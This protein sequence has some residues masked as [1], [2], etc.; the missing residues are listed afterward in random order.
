MARLDPHSCADDEQP[1]ARHLRLRLSVDFDARRIE[2]VSTLVFEG[3]A[4]GLLDLDSKEIEILGVSAGS[5]EAVPF[6]VG[7]DEPILGRRVRLTLPEGTREVRLRYRTSPE[8]PALQWLSP[9]QTAGG[10]RPFLFSQCQPI[11]ARSLAPLA[12]TARNR[13]TYEAEVEIDEPLAAVMSAGP[14]G[15]ARGTRPGTRVFRFAMPQAIPPY[16]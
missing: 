9:E 3:P 8:A 11:H 2:G 12:D 14:A 7:P 6:E 13:L 5:G 4:S 10:Q 16:L 1:R 15:E